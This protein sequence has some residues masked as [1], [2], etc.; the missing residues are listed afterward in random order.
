MLDSFLFKLVYTSKIR[1]DEKKTVQ[2]RFFIYI[3]IKCFEYMRFKKKIPNFYS[4][5]CK[6]FDRIYSFSNSFPI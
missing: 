5:L 4:F 3:Q 2:E 6:Q 1:V